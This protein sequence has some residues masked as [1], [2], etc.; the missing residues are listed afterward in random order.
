VVHVMSRYN[1]VFDLDR[2]RVGI[3]RSRCG[4]DT[5]ETRAKC[6]CPAVSMDAKDYRESQGV[7]ECAPIYVYGMCRARQSKSAAP[8]A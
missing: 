5:E 1:V 6:N 8:T 3:A 2:Q 4:Y 7:T